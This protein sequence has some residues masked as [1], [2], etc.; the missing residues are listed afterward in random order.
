MT[1]SDFL[2]PTAISAAVA[3]FVGAWLAARFALHRYYREQMWQRKAAAYTAIFEALHLIDNWYSK[4]LDAHFDNRELSDEIT[5]KLR[6]DA[7]DAEAQLEKR[8]ASETWVVSHACQARLR[9]MTAELQKRQDDWFSHLDSGTAIIAS[10]QADLRELVMADLN[11]EP[12]FLK[13]SKR[14]KRLKSRNP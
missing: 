4:H 13:I 9:K 12:L 7:N 6:Q 8:L 3:S 2:T 11:V 5:K 10:A 14:W 1:V